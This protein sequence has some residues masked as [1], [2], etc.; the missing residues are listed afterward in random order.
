MKRVL[1]FVFLV[2]L[3][4]S[5]SDEKLDERLT[6]GTWYLSGTTTYEYVYDEE[7]GDGQESVDYV[8]ESLGVLTFRFKS[9]GTFQ[10]R[11]TQPTH[12]GGAVYDTWE[13]G[14]W[15]HKDQK[16]YMDTKDGAWVYD[17][18]IHSSRMS[19][20]YYDDDLKISEVFKNK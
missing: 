8:S 16:L 10:V 15:E 3:C 13:Q 5:C 2:C 20:E 1:E 4:I 12:F 9:D 14:T 11:A 17:V 18:D 7:E 19:L 6:E